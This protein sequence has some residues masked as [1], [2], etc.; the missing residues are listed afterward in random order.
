[1]RTFDYKSGR[2]HTHTYKKKNLPILIWQTAPRTHQGSPYKYTNTTGGGV[3][4]DATSTSSA[5]LT[6][7]PTSRSRYDDARAR[8]QTH[9]RAVLA[10]NARHMCRP[11]HECRPWMANA[12]RSAIKTPRM[13]AGK[14]SALRFAHSHN[15]SSLRCEGTMGFTVFVLCNILF[16]GTMFWVDVCT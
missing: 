2:P 7:C 9:T 6:V 5:L 8:E 16:G 10:V 12:K 3:T 13:A 15:A 1:M 11:P 14:F 4:R